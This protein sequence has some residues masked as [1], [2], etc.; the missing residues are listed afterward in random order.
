MALHML[1]KDP[2]SKNGG[3]PTAYYDDVRDTYVL[4]GVTVTD[5]DR[6]SQM[7]VPGHESVIEFPRRMLQFLPEVTGGDGA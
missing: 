7:D 1:G 3:S 6:L 2:E 4:Q 5:E